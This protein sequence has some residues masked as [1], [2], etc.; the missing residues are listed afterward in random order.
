MNKRTAS[1]IVTMLVAIILTV[2]FSWW[3]LYMPIEGAERVVILLAPLPLIYLG[4]RYGSPTAIVAGAI[5][6]SIIGFL[7]HPWTA[8]QTIVLY[9]ILPLLMPAIAGLFARNT[10]RTLNNRRY[11]SVYLNIWTA[12]IAVYLAFG[13][14]KYQLALLVVQPP[15][16]ELSTIFHWSFWLS[17]LGSAALSAFTLSLMARSKPS[18]IIPKRSRFLSR[19]ETSS[20]LND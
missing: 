17:I 6:G 19:R 15:T 8:W 11:F 3:P 5:A 7:K 20:L 13:L 16:V 10:H 18:L 14:V 4:L 2:V 12:S 1:L 9:E